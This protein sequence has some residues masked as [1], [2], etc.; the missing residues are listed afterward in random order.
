MRLETKRREVVIK[1]LPQERSTEIAL[2]A[3]LTFSTAV[4]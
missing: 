4:L 1:S 3:Q 2:K